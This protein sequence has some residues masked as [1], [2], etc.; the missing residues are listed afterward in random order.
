MMSRIVLDADREP[1]RR[2]V[3]AAVQ[4]F[5]GESCWCVVDAGWI[6]SDF[7]SP[8]LAS[9]EKSLS[10]S[11]QRFAR[12]ASP[13]SRNVNIAPAPVG[14]ILRRAVVSRILGKPG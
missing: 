12:A 7:A 1:D 5:A 3:D 13:R 11:M 14:K 8:T 6:T 10:R 9:S 2:F 4:P